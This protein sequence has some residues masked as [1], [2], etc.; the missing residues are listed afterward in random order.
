MHPLQSFL[1]FKTLIFANPSPWLGG[2]LGGI[3]TAGIFG[4]ISHVRSIRPVLFFL[5]ERDGWYLRNIGSGPALDVIVASADNDKRWQIPT[6]YH[7][8]SKDGNVKLKGLGVAEYLAVKYTGIN[9]HWYSTQCGYN[10]NRFSNHRFLSIVKREPLKEFG[11]VLQNISEL[12]AVEAGRMSQQ[13]L[14]ALILKRTFNNS[15]EAA[16]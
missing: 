2:V 1:D 6:L 5:Y 15:Y 14:T 8:I 3:L 13:E 9:R 16:E 11:V 10:I 12:E 7:P 4:W